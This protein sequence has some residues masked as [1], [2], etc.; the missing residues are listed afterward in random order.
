MGAISD[1]LSPI[2][3][4]KFTLKFRSRQIPFLYQESM[5]LKYKENEDPNTIKKSNL[6][7]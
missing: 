1:V 2:Y 4:Y 6:I 3:S 5:D 7:I